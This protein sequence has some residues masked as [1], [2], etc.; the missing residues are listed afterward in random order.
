MYKFLEPPYKLYIW[1]NVNEREIAIARKQERER[2]EK[3]EKREKKNIKTYQ[4]PRRPTGKRMI[5]LE[6][7]PLRMF[8]VVVSMYKYNDSSHHMEW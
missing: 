4:A 7:Y 5:F 8:G 2:R 6:Q 3:R 1:I